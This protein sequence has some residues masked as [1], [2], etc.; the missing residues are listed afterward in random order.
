MTVYLVNPAGAT[1]D[2]SGA[3]QYGDLRYANVRF[4]YAD[5]IDDEAL[6]VAAERNLLQK[7]DSFDP[8]TDYFLIAGDD[9]QLVAMAA[10]LGARHPWFRVLRWDRQAKG[11]YVVKIQTRVPVNRVEVLFTT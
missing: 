5:E 6:P 10:M 11:Y 2:L 8:E 7:V 4:V 9:L 3:K 1:L